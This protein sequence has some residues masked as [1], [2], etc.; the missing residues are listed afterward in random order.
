MPKN[1]NQVSNLDELE[2]QMQEQEHQEQVQFNPKTVSNNPE[3]EQEHQESEY[4]PKDDEKHLYHVE[5]EKPL[6]NQSTGKKVSSPYVQ[7]F[8]RAEYNQF[9]GKKS[10]KDKS[11]AEMLGYTVKVLYTPEI[12]F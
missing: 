4:V 2:A 5:L 7:K 10:E 11:N 9:V 8:T 12:V 6:Y 1:S 3:Q